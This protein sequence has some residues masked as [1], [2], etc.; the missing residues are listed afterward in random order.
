MT[1]IAA[2]SL[3]AQVG[4]RLKVVYTGEAVSEADIKNALNGIEGAKY[5]NVNEKNTFFVSL[6]G[7]ISK[8]LK[9][10]KSNISTPFALLQTDSVGPKVGGEL[11]RQGSCFDFVYAWPGSCLC[12]IPLQLVFCS[13]CRTGTVSRCCCRRWNFYSA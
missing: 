7:Q 10:I 8:I 3:D 12:C 11:R 9:S 2:S 13:R 1:G 5:E 4:A 6:P